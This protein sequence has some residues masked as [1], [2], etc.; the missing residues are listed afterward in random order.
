MASRLHVSRGRACPCAAYAG[1]DAL[2]FDRIRLARVPSPAGDLRTCPYVV[3]G[4][5]R[6]RRDPPLASLPGHL[7]SVMLVESACLGHVVVRQVASQAI[8]AP[9]PNTARWMMPGTEGAGPSV[10]ASVAGLAQ[11]TLTRGLGV[12][13]ALCDDRSPVT[14]WTADALGPSEGTNRLKTVRVV[15]E[16]LPV[17]HEASIADWTRWNTCLRQDEQP[18]REDV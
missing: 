10:A 12:V 8:Q 1:R 13:T 15:D 7:L 11:R 6:R 4:G 3:E 17:Y 18:S 9:Y 2:V 16:R 5:R 14:P